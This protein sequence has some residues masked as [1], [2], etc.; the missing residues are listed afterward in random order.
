MMA[1]HTKKGIHEMVVL[2]WIWVIVLFQ[3]VLLLPVGLCF[4]FRSN[5]VSATQLMLYQEIRSTYVFLIF[6]FL[7]WQLHGFKMCLTM[8]S[9]ISMFSPSQSRSSNSTRKSSLDALESTLQK[10]DHILSHSL[11]QTGLVAYEYLKRSL[12]VALE[13]KTDHRTSSR[14]LVPCSIIKKHSH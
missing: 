2:Y 1:E 13:S 9:T 10:H 7:N 8:F 4:Q 12:L 5:L 11:I 14:C 3:S 6:Q